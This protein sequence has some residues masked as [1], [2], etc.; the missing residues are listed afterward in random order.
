MAEIFEAFPASEVKPVLGAEDQE[1]WGSWSTDGQ[2][3]S[4]STGSGWHSSWGDPGQKVLTGGL[5]RT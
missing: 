5:L 3:C 1:T 2:V 4:S